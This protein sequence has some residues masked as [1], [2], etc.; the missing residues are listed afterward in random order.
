MA[1]KQVQKQPSD[2]C[3]AKEQTRE[4]KKQAVSHPYIWRNVRIGHQDTGRGKA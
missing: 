1:A 2:I 3:K 4:R